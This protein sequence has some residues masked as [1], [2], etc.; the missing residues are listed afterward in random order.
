M[1]RMSENMVEFKVA[2]P[3]NSN[4]DAV[5]LCLKGWNELTVKGFSDGRLV[6]HDGMTAIVAYAPNGRDMIPAGVLLFGLES[7]FR[8]CWITLTYVIPEAR[9]GGVYRFMRSALE[10]M[11]TDNGVNTIEFATHLRNNAMR[12]TSKRMGDSEEFVILVHRIQR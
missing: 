5:A 12:E 8:R 2:S 3:A 11:A 6:F 1:I 7:E 4:P 10:K 9:G